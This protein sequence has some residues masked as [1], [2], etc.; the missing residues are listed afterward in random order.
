MNDNEIERVLAAWIDTGG[1]GEDCPCRIVIVD[2]KV[3]AISEA[4]VGEGE[5]EVKNTVRLGRWVFGKRAI[6]AGYSEITNNLYIAA[7]PKISVGIF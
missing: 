4:A 7:E 5:M 1:G 2:R 3:T 6:Y